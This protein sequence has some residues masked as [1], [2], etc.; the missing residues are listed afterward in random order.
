[1]EWAA[2][3]RVSVSGGTV[4]A[5]RERST[6]EPDPARPLRLAVV[7]ADPALRARLQERLH[8]TA[9]VDVRAWAAGVD[10]LLL[11]DTRVD[12]CL[13]T[14]PVPDPAAARLRGRGCAVAGLPPGGDPLAVALAAD[15]ARALAARAS[16]AVPR[17][18]LAPRQQEV[19]AAY[20]AGNDLLPT[21]ARQ[22]GME[23]ETLKTHLRRIRA[24][25]AEVG[26][27]A[28]TRRDLYV[29]AVEDG[30]LAPPSGRPWR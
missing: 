8:G 20:A 7:S 16:G 14:E 4:P 5:R 23:R 12:V 6:V 10:L 26:R 17:P 27:P 15:A 18:Q 3:L 24:K 11:L 13:C 1:M 28:P 25:Y 30:L 9:G 21:V 29:R 22:L 2:E 19:L